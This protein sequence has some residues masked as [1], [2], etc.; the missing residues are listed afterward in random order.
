MNCTIQQL[1]Q[2]VWTQL[3]RIH[4]RRHRRH[5]AITATR[6]TV[7]AAPITVSFQQLGHPL[8]PAFKALL[9]CN[10]RNFLKGSS[11]QTPLHSLG[12]C[13]H[14]TCCLGSKQ[15]ARQDTDD[16]FTRMA[17]QKTNQCKSS[18]LICN[19]ERMNLPDSG[20]GGGLGEAPM[21]SFA[22]ASLPES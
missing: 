9:Q 17:A 3:S 14:Q 15:S 6:G 5:A 13:L 11:H 7:I 2:K 12:K 1:Q 21:C 18:H 20:G 10:T 4:Q 16:I 8:T 22:L 19:F